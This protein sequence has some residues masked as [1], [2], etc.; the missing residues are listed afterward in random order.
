MDSDSG[1]RA[2]GGGLRV[3]RATPM[4]KSKKVAKV[5]DVKAMFAARF[6]PNR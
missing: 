3:L 2:Q 5:L 6:G 4:Q 1:S